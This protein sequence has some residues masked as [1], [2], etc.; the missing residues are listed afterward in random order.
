MLNTLA[1]GLTFY[2]SSKRMLGSRRRS[3][4][5]EQCCATYATVGAIHVGIRTWDAVL[6]FFLRRFA[7][8]IDHTKLSCQMVRRK[9]YCMVASCVL[10]LLLK[11]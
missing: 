9:V 4:V 1:L 7:N 11:Q 3:E 10:A 5:C 2:G 6:P 8:S